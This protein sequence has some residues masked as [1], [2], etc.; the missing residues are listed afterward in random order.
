MIYR[1]EHEIAN[2]SLCLAFVSTMN[3]A[4]HS[5]F[6]PQD[7][8]KRQSYAWKENPRKDTCPTIPP[9]VQYSIH[10]SSLHQILFH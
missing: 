8:T 7:R 4:G 2:T 10:P 3:R 1:T 5:P 9:Q 6:H